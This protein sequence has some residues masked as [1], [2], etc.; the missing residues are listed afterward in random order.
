MVLNF[1]IIYEILYIMDCNVHYEYLYNALYIKALS[2]VI[3]RKK[4]CP[5]L[6]P[7]EF[8]NLDKNF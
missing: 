7:F 5:V 2:I 1:E 4:I 3:Q 8:H 6:G